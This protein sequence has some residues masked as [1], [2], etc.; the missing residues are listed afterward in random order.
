MRSISGA[1]VPAIGV[2]LLGAG[3]ISC[4]DR[5]AGSGPTGTSPTAADPSTT[6]SVTEGV[7]VG[8]ASAL[9][10]PHPWG[11]DTPVEAARSYRWGSPSDPGPAD[12]VWTTVFSGPMTVSLI[13]EDGATLDV[14]PWPDGSWVVIGGQRCG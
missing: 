6:C 4:A 2:L 11:A 3:V 1:L 10:E 12:T 7:A 5:S 9:P 14:V 13:S 8:L